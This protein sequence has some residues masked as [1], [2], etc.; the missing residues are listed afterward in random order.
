MVL[1]D[2]RPV[3][4]CS[5]PQMIPNTLNL[6]VVGGFWSGCG[7]MR[8]PLKFNIAMEHGP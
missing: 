3:A 5:P 8:Y 6:K 2:P 1:S 4:S 7:I